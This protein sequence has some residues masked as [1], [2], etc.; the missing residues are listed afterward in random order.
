MNT[1]QYPTLAAAFC[2]RDGKNRCFHFKM[3]NKQDDQAFDPLRDNPLEGK[4][5]K[6][7][8]RRI[9]REFIS[10]IGGLLG[11]IHWPVAI[12]LLVGLVVV[13]ISANLLLKF[14]ADVYALETENSEIIG[15]LAAVYTTATARQEIID[16]LENPSETPTETPS[17]TMSAHFPSFGATITPTEGIILCANMEQAERLVYGFIIGIG[18]KN[19]RISFNLADDC[20]TVFLGFKNGDFIA[21]RVSSDGKQFVTCALF[22]GNVKTYCYIEFTRDFSAAYL[23]AYGKADIYDSDKDIEFCFAETSQSY[24]GKCR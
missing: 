8:S 14:S 11:G 24:N 13:L 15:T 19:D 6:M 23:N 2:L 20:L 1:P 16:V 21:A 10:R 4:E 7:Q 5:N 18:K 17:L 9:L 12:F 3:K 22:Q